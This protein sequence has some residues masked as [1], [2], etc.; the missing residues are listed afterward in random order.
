MYN[1]FAHIK[2]LFAHT[3]ASVVPMPATPSTGALTTPVSSPDLVSDPTPPSMRDDLHTRPAASTSAASPLSL[4][5]TEASSVQ[6][7]AV[8]LDEQQVT[9][10]PIPETVKPKR[11]KRPRKQQIVP[12]IEREESPPTRLGL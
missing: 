12:I 9:T 8:V 3:P 4:P 1:L 2:S 7:P 11:A 10:A 5:E 6:V